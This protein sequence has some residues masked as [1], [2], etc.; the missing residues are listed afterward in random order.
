M[1]PDWIDPDIKDNPWSKLLT[2]RMCLSHRTGFANWR[3]QNL[4]TFQ[5]Y[6]RH[7]RQ[8]QRR[9]GI[10]QRIAR[11]DLPQQAGQ[12]LPDAAAPAAP[13]ITPANA[14]VIPSRR[15]RR[16]PGTGLPPATCGCRSPASAASPG[17][18]A[19]RISRSPPA[20]PKA[21]NEPTSALRNCCPAP[22]RP[23]LHRSCGRDHRPCGRSPAPSGV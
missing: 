11:L 15:G 2:L 8:Q 20:V 5:C 14:S 6:Q 9:H 18:K 16:A 17:T 12:N 4:L 19:R 10:N 22:A 13:R 7:R 1:A 23:P 3:Y 21:A